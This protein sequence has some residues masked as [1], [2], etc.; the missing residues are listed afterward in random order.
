MQVSD[1]RLLPKPKLVRFMPVF[2]FHDDMTEKIGSSRKALLLQEQAKA[3]VRKDMAEQIMLNT[4]SD[5][6]DKPKATSD[7]ADLKEHMH[8]MRR[9]IPIV[10]HQ[11][12][13]TPSFE[14]ILSHDDSS[15][16]SSDVSVVTGEEWEEEV[17]DLKDYP[18]AIADY[19][20]YSWTIEVY[21]REHLS[22]DTVWFRVSYNGKAGYRELEDMEILEFIDMAIKMNP[23]FCFYV[24]T[25]FGDGDDDIA[26][27]ESDL[28][29]RVLKTIIQ[30]AEYQDGI[31]IPT[32]WEMLRKRTLKF[33]KKEKGCFL[34][35]LFPVPLGAAERRS[36]FAEF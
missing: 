26:L 12:E 10:P 34:S 9:L 30:Q 11:P 4:S 13:E 16:V 29:I 15:T 22:G 21:D 2:N 1:L 27:F 25:K 7:D 14:L 33:Q 19:R 5:S 36:A 6:E 32:E 3:L 35:W 20:K 23:C 8:P 31:E 28:I 17:W 24:K 18:I